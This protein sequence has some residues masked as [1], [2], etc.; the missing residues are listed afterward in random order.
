[1]WLHKD[2]C[3]GSV[4]CTLSHPAL[5]T[6]KV[7]SSRLCSLEYWQQWR[8]RTTDRPSRFEAGAS[9]TD[10]SQ[11]VALPVA[12]SIWPLTQSREFAM[13]QYFRL[14]FQLIP[15]TELE[16]REGHNKGYDIAEMMRA[17]AEL[18]CQHPPLILPSML[19]MTCT[20]GVAKSA[21]K[22]QME[23]R[24]ANVSHVS[25]LQLQ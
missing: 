21:Q 5:C 16:I 19:S 7:G 24:T 22:L 10:P 4:K 11:G 3:S 23:T 13:I 14:G 17:R 12:I 25:S 8:R 20:A 15:T 18:D 2:L 9:S 6:F 1:M